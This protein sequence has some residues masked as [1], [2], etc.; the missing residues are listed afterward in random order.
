MAIHGM[1]KYS[2]VKNIKYQF[3]MFSKDGLSVIIVEN[4]LK[5]TGT[6]K[7]DTTMN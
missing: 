4:S 1:S 5:A 7:V 2:T 3:G 6:E